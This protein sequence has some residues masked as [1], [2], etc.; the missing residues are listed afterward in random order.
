MKVLYGVQ[1]TGNGHITRARVMAPAL[2]KAG[3]EVDYLFSGRAPDGFF[4]MEP[5]GEYQCKRGLTFYMEG[6]KVDKWKTLTGNNPLRLVQDIL[7]LNLDDYDLVITDFEPVTAW[8]AKLKGVPSIGIAHQYAFLHQLPDSKSG[9]FFR[10]QI[11]C[12]APA[13][14]AV[15]I[16]WHH[17]NQAICPPL[18]QPPLFPPAKCANKVVVYLP[19]DNVEMIKRALAVH[20]AYDFFVYAPVDQALDDG[21]VHF[22]PFAREGFHRDLSDCAGVICNSGFGLLSEAIQYGKKILTL[23]QLGQAEQESNAEVLEHLGLGTVIHDLYSERV[24]QWLALPMP[25]PQLFPDLA[26]VLAE[27]IA[28]GCNRTVQSVVDDAWSRTC[29]PSVSGG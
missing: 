22:R 2:A 9:F 29:R 15:G 7:A 6:S 17:F 11:K 26:T 25:E 28:A 16:H 21:N 5:F 18:I 10:H 19:H 12:F 20:S 4:N 24:A 3:V 8:A 1:A 27:W 13:K 14:I 23:P